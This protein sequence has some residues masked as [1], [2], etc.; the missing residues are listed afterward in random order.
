[1][2]QSSATARL[3]RPG[4]AGGALNLGIAI[5]VLVVLLPLILN[6]ATSSPPTAAEFSPNAKQV[7][8]QAP[9]GQAAAVNGSGEGKAPGQGPGVT[10]APPKV[11][12]PRNQVKR[13]VGPPPLRQ[14]EDP[15]SPPCIAFWTGDNGGATARG[16]TR[17][18]VYIAVPTPEN[19]QAIYRALFKF[20]NDRFQFY[21]R[22]LVPEFCGS[23]GGGAGSSDQTNQNADAALAAAGCQGLPQPFASTFYRQNNGAYYMPAMGCR[24]KT[25]V[26]GSYSPYD[27]KFLNRCAPYQY[28]YSMEVDEEFAN[29][30]EWVCARLAGKNAQWADG[31][32]TGTPPRPL[33]Q[34]PRNFGILLEPFTEDDPV[35]RPD[36]LTPMLSR[37]KACGVN[38]ANNNVII[39]PVSGLFDPTT[40]Q[41]A[42]LQLRRNDVSSVICMCN[43]FSFGSLQRAATTSA[44]RPEWITSTFGINDVNSSFTL[45]VSPPDQLRRT[46]GITFNPRII[47]PLLNPYNVAVQEGDP[48]QAPDTTASVEAKLEVYRALLVLASGIQMAGPKLT[49]ETFRDGLRN[50]VFPNPITATRAGAVGLRPNG[51]SLTKDAAEWWWST[52]ARGPFT[53]SA[54]KPGTVCYLNGGNRYELGSWPKG[55]APFFSGTCDSGA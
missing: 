19:A 23:S 13:C 27:S 17:D 31:N 38:V 36:A 26:V 14:I 6:A 33:N 15:Q 20:F 32:D 46:F 29:I 24:Y 1:M 44:Y 21:G 16:V 18:A 5:A 49:V 35:A 47:P 3:R 45:G 34:Q 25:I 54:A 51:F 53:D 40:A 48:S 55:D 10:E 8:K 4:R 30:G 41:N 37:L 7:I 12:V 2:T 52:S 42:M 50:T 11:A 43:F 9:P 39:N 28:Q 22:K